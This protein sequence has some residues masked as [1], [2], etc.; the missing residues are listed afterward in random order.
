MTFG[1]FAAGFL[2]RPLGAIFYGHLGDKHGRRRALLWSVLVVGLPTFLLG[3][4]PGHGKVGMVAP[5]LV[6]VIR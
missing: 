5:I 6:G 4:I 1:V 2:M 3:L